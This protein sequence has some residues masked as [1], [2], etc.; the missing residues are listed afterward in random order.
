MSQAR[1][2]SQ[3]LRPLDLAQKPDFPSILNGY[4]VGSNNFTGKPIVRSDGGKN[5]QVISNG[6]NPVLGQAVTI[7]HDQTAPGSRTLTALFRNELVSSTGLPPTPNRNSAQDIDSCV[8]PP[9]E[10]EPEE[11]EEPEEPLPPA[12]PDDNDDDED[13][14]DED[15]EAPGEGC[16]PDSDCQWYSASNGDSSNCPAGTSYSGFAEL[17]GG[18]FMV[19][20]CGESRPPGDGCPGEPETTGWQCVNGTCEQLP[21]GLFATKAECEQSCGNGTPWAV[22]D[23]QCTYLGEGGSFSTLEE[24]QATLPPPPFEGGQCPIRY[25]IRYRVEWGG[26]WGPSSNPGYD[27]GSWSAPSIYGPLGAPFLRYVSGGFSDKFNWIL[28]CHGPTGNSTELI[29]ASRFV[30]QTDG[31]GGSIADLQF[32]PHDPGQ[33][34]DCGSLPPEC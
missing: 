6:A 15:P 19:L 34:D 32:R 10:G 11:L 5:M 12:E 14:E 13:N 28:P 33:Q 1:R 27:N 17:A 30:G 4:T 7:Q 20:C 9:S 23:C 8:L 25:D 21:A 26:G 16:Y 3:L 18:Q 24:C 29:I 2:L 31:A 22:E